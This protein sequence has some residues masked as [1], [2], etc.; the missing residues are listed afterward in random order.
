MEMILDSYYTDG[1]GGLEVFSL[2]P[3]E[4]QLSC[5]TTIVEVSDAFIKRYR[6]VV[7]EWDELQAELSKLDVKAVRYKSWDGEI[8]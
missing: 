8:Y 2:L 6:R 4:T 3:I 1:D 5:C 7:T